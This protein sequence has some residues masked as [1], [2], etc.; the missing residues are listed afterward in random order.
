MQHRFNL[1][2]L[3]ARLL[4]RGSALNLPCCPH[5]LRLPAILGL[6]IRSLDPV[7][8]PIENPLNIW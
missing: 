2:D 3:K 7:H 6:C 5:P 8:S 1:N 4:L